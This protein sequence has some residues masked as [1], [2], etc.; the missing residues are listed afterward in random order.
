MFRD[1][2]CSFEDVRVDL[3]HAVDGMGAHNAQ[4]GHVN[5]LLSAFF[6][7]G[8]AAKAIH[9]AGVLS[10]NSLQNSKVHEKQK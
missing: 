10:S 2:H 8:H 1:V 5:P 6:N 3:S 4:M 7:E 9:I